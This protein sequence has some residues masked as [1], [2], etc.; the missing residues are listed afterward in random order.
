MAHESDD[1]FAREIEAFEARKE[2]LLLRH[3]GRYALLYGDDLLGVYGTREEAYVAGLNKVGNVPM[4]I[5]S[6]QR[7]PEPV[8]YLPALHN[9]SLR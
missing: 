5:Q 2:E 1:L 9:G 6:I 4:L 7:E 3:E 8:E